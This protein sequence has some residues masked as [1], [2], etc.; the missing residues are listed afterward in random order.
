MVKRYRWGAAWTG[1]GALLL[2]GCGGHDGAP[3]GGVELP[4]AAVRVAEVEA[5]EDT[6][7]QGLPGTVYPA[8]QA[9][10]ASKIMATVEE[11]D[12][13]IGQRVREGE[14]LLVLSAEEISAQVE[15]AEAALAQLQRNLEREQ[16][17]FAQNATTA[18]AVRTLE[19]QIRVSQARLA[20]ARIMQGYTRLRAPFDGTVTSKEVRRGDLATPG[21]PLLT[22]EG[23]GSLQVHVQV[24]DSLV[25]LEHGKA[26]TVEAKG[27]QWTARLSEWSPAADP[28]SRTRLAKLDLA[29][30]TPLR[31]GQYVRVLWPAE[32]SRSLWM[33]ASALSA[34]GQLQRAFVV[35]DGRL[36]MQM[37]RTGTHRGDRL[38]VL[39]GLHEGDRVV[40]D[41][42]TGLRDGQPAKVLP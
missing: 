18:E 23:L 5:L 6:R 10:I 4:E 17:L 15:Q 7:H 20:E 33:P 3:E 1:L 37:I 19:D 36:E 31:S 9:V 26:V 42:S 29:E 28:A 41:P 22:V 11:A 13:V 14:V 39:A 21:T 25:A 24:P 12:I 35:L 34:M 27:E 30:D 38:E 2:A 16:A 32:P 40:L 8:D